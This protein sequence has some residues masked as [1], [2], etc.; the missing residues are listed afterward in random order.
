[1]PAAVGRR[2]LSIQEDGARRPSSRAELLHLLREC[3][4]SC[5]RNRVESLLGRRDYSSAELS[6]KLRT[7]GYPTSVVEELVERAVSCGLVDDARFGASFARSKVASG[8]GRLKI[9]RELERRGISPDA[10]D[11]WPEEYV[12]SDAERERA[13]SLARRRRLTGKNDYEKTVRFLCGRGFSLS[14]SAEVARDVLSEDE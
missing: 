3:S 10:I 13:L 14:L 5:G 4:L 1:M 9:E 7:D 6:E 8:W 12:S 2:L 11:G